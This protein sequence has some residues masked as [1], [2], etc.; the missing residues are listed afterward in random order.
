MTALQLAQQ[1][2]GAVPCHGQ[3]AVTWTPSA[4]AQVNAMSSWANPVDP[5]AD[6]NEN[7]NCAITLNPA[8]T[9]DW[10]K[11]CTVVTHEVGHLLGRQHSPDPADVMHAVYTTPTP[12]CQATPEPEGTLTAAVEQARAPVQAQSAAFA[13]ASQSAPPP[14]PSAPTPTTTTTGAVRV[15][16]TSKTVTAAPAVAVL[17]SVKATA[18]TPAGDKRTQCLRRAARAGSTVR[19]RAL[20]RACATVTIKPSL[21]TASA[22][23]RDSFEQ[24]GGIA[25]RSH[26]SGSVAIFAPFVAL[27]AL[28]ILMR[29]WPPVARRHQAAE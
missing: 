8:A 20:R 3:A 12:E 11:L 25:V 22:A 29:V 26:A 27:L 21:R 13:A 2:W 5:Y 15:G 17:S 24:L 18:T 6:P 1:H 4:D 23:S 19:R 9:W 16:G 7:V 14:P 10:P 28:L